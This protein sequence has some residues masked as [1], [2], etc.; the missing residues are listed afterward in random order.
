MAKRIIDG[1]ECYSDMEEA[2][3]QGCSHAQHY[4]SLD[5]Y[6]TPCPGCGEQRYAHME[7]EDGQQHFYLAAKGKPV[8]WQPPISGGRNS[9]DV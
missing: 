9:M 6:F 4:A 3:E 8:G 2:N 1:V 5:Y 7:G